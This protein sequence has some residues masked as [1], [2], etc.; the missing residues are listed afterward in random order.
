MAEGAPPNSMWKTVD[1]YPNYL[2]SDCGEIYSKYSNK[3]L[4]PVCHNNGY[5]CVELFNNGK[6]KI[7]SVH[8][9]VA[10]A[11]L[12][13]PCSF[14]QVNH[15]DEN[16]A[17]NAASNLEWC[18]AKYNMN[19]GNAAKTRHLNIDY[20]SPERIRICSENGKKCGIPVD[21][22]S[23]DGKYIRSYCSASDAARQTG[24]D[25]A[26]ILACC[27]GKKSRK[28]VKGYL[29]KLSK[30]RNDDLLASQ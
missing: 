21:Q 1:G 5:M 11:F 28:T 14:P 24:A 6:S 16:K 20:H 3:I 2:V 4:R 18:T 26:H 15:K 27:R 9:I 23:L 7:M 29:W 25:E 13:N 30:E 8:R 10:T 22:Y 12:P 17:N 19:Y